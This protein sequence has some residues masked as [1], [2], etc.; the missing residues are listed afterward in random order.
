MGPT[1]V[2]LAPDGP[3]DGHMNL[4][5]RDISGWSQFK[6]AILSV[7]S[8]DKDKTIS[9]W[10]LNI[11]EEHTYMILHITVLYTRQNNTVLYARQNWQKTIFIK[12]NETFL[13]MRTCYQW[14][15]LLLLRSYLHCRPMLSIF[16]PVW[17]RIMWMI[18]TGMSPHAICNKVQ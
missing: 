12:L 18:S 14:Y 7:Y 2:L 11:F 5:I 8:H 16:V 10:H 9:H 17:P 15:V 13:L 1:W 3:H 6:D 4:A